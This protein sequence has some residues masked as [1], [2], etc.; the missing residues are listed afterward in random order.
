M[1]SAVVV[2]MKTK[3]ETM[4]L[5][6]TGMLSDTFRVG[7][8]SCDG[9]PAELEAAREAS[10]LGLAEW[11]IARGGYRITAEGRAWLRNA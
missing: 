10:H 2:S 8:L 11:S 4:R 7:T 3:P 6:L 1:M 5:T 9:T